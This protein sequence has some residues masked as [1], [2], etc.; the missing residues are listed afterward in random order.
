[1]RPHQGGQVGGQ[2]SQGWLA[3]RFVSVLKACGTIRGLM[4]VHAPPVSPAVGIGTIL[5]DL[6]PLIM[7]V[8]VSQAS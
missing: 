4:R 5:K 1:M 6:G 3:L 8:A 7:T 2:R